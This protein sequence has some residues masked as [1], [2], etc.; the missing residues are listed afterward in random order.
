MNGHG[1]AAKIRGAR[2]APSTVRYRGIAAAK[3]VVEGN[4]K[5]VVA[6]N[7]AT[8]TFHAWLASQRQVDL[9][10][11]HVSVVL[12]RDGGGYGEWGDNPE[13]RVRNIKVD[14]RESLNFHSC[15]TR[16]HVR[17]ENRF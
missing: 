7:S 5:R 13:I 9:E 11:S 2:D 6:A 3:G 12:C 16:R 10:I 8:A 17:N 14:I 4:A 1:V 15:R